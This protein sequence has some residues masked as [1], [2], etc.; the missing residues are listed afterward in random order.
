MSRLGIVGWKGSGKTT[1]VVRLLSELTRRGYVVSTLKHAHH[2]FDIDQPGRDSHA[3]RVAGAA[4][5]M[6]S[7][8]KR[9]ALVHEVRNGEEATIEDLRD[10]PPLMGHN[11]PPEPLENLPFT[12][13]EGQTIKLVIE[14]V[15]REAEK[16]TPDVDR[17]KEGASKLR[18]TASGLGHWLKKRLDKGSD[19]FAKTMG[20]GLAAALLAQLTALYEALVGAS[21]V[22]ANWIEFLVASL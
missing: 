10:K 8:E 20:A 16:P 21:Q 14:A 22:I 7:S 4:E 5:V 17:V 1:L 2:G 6:I 15:R 3:H 11:Q 18:F 13:D 12:R 19:A 9:W